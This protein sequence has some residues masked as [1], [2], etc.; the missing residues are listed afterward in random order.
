MMRP[1]QYDLLMAENYH[2]K[3]CIRLKR[4]TS[5][6]STYKTSWSKSKVGL[7]PHPIQRWREKKKTGEKERESHSAAFLRIEEQ[8]F[9]DGFMAVTFLS[10]NKYHTLSRTNTPLLSFSFSIPM[11]TWSALY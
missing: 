3:H 1:S 5:R 11:I 10:T 6:G 8:I 2:D 7:R 4:T 9:S